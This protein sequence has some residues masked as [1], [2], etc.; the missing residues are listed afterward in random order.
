MYMKKA[1]IHPF[2]LRL[3]NFFSTRFGI[4]LL[5]AGIGLLFF[6]SYYGPG[7][8]NPLNAEWLKYPGDLKQHYIGSSSFVKSPWAFPIGLITNE[9]YP[10]GVPIT[11][12][13]ALPIVSLPLKLFAGVLPHNFQLF[14]LWGVLCFMLQG[15]LAVLIMQRWTKRPVL[16]LITSV[17]FV[18][19]PIIMARMFAHT[20]LASQWVILAAIFLYLE[21]ARFSWFA[22]ISLW[23][24]LFVV[25][26]LIHPYFMPM[27]GV[28]LLV[29]V[30]KSRLSWV[31]SPL[32]VALPIAVSG[33]V[34]WLIGGF[35]AEHIPTLGLGYYGFNLNSLVNP[36]GWSHFIPEFPVVSHAPESLAYLGLGILILVPITILAA[37]LA[38]K[39]RAHIKKIAKRY[40]TAR[41]AAVALVLLGLFL[42]SVGTNVLSGNAIVWKFEV[43]PWLLDFWSNFRS[44]ARLFWPLYY[45]IIITVL[46]V[47]ATYFKKQAGYAFAC[48]IFAAIMLVQVYDIRASDAARKRRHAVITTEYTTYVSPLSS[49]VWSE[50]VKG[51]R[52]LVYLE[53]MPMDAFYK[54]SD[55]ADKYSLTMNTGYYAREVTKKIPRLQEH[56]RDSLLK[57]KVEPQILYV[58]HN[59]DYIN[60]LPETMKARAHLIDNYWLIY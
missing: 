36:L 59:T 20:A 50:A 4:A 49:P 30:I 13:D 44:S 35:W 18:V 10:Y 55:I 12:M 6:L 42:A 56:Y 38:I 7:V 1:T 34:F 28:F 51:K 29:S 27:V 52:N 26:I 58:T 40:M 17:F 32:Q 11:F 39:D 31:L 46:A 60:R 48:I 8:I 14:G 33:A 2:F 24:L 9:A 53:D 37:L 5:G 57:G 45:L 16:T 15:F 19:S 43:W 3:R 41:N 25:T 23:T 47:S 54:L 21:R 22:R